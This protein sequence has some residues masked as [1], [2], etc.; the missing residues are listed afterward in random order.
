MSGRYEQEV[1]GREQHLRAQHAQEEGWPLRSHRESS[2]RAREGATS[3]AQIEGVV[4]WPLRGA[5][6]T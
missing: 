4:L 2:C 5:T 3:T 6:R 1:K